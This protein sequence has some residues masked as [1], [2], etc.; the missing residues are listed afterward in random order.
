M[1]IVTV[2]V[3]MLLVEA[4]RAGDSGDM[5]IVTGYTDTCEYTGLYVKCGDQC[6]DAYY[7]KCYC[8]SSSS[9]S[10]SS[11]KL[12]DSVAAASSSL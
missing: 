4:V 10:L 6:I 11:A 5:M 12:D 9:D 8:G 7:D 3:L 1:K 2:I